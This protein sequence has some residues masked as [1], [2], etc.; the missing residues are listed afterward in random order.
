M[1]PAAQPVARAGKA[2]AILVDGR[3]VLIDLATGKPLWNVDAKVDP[4]G[5]PVLAPDLG[6]VLMA[7]REGA[8][9]ALSLTDG[10]PR[11]RRTAELGPLEGGLA[12]AERSIYVSNTRGRLL[13]L[14]ASDGRTLWDQL[15]PAVPA[16]PPRRFASSIYVPLRTGEIVE[17]NP[18]D[19]KKR[20]SVQVEGIP[21][22]SPVICG[23]RLMLGAG[24]SVFALERAED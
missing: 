2:I 4:A 15:Q 14:D 23:T 17:V 12:V 1:A 21:S 18:S 9:V 11:Y 7:S 19:G 10:A 3:A 8:V 22:A 5:A 16:A 24:F 13:A 20:G 6:F